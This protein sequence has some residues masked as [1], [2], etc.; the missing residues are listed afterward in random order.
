MSLK[1]RWKCHKVPSNS[2]CSKQ[3]MEFDDVRMELLEEFICESITVLH[4]R[5]QW[6]LDNHPHCNKQR[7]IGHN[8]KEL[9]DQWRNNNKEHI[10]A[11]D[12]ANK[13]RRNELLRIRRAKKKLEASAASTLETKHTTN[14]ITN[15][16]S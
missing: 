7:A 14:C 4:Q 10:R 8:M 9:R 2:A 16:P 3:L 12:I 11:Y 15:A 5:E 6:Y 1:D 13:D